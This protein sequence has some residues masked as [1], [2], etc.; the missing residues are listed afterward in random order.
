MEIRNRSVDGATQGHTQDILEHFKAMFASSRGQN[1]VRRSSNVGYAEED[2]RLEMR[3]A[4][5]NAALFI[6]ALVYGCDVLREQDIPVPST[7]R[8][9]NLLR[10]ERTGYVSPKPASRGTRL[11]RLRRHWREASS[12]TS[13]GTDAI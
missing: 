7:E 1:S 5:E 11:R 13:D 9:N 12:S 6:Q 4:A 8:L 2:M 10:E 3:Q